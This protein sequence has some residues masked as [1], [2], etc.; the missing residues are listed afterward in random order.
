MPVSPALKF[1]VVGEL[2]LVRCVIALPLEGAP[3][4]RDEA[5]TS[6]EVIVWVVNVVPV[7]NRRLAPVVPAVVSILLDI[8]IAEK[9]FSVSCK[10]QNTDLQMASH[11][12]GNWTEHDLHSVYKEHQRPR[13]RCSLSEKLPTRWKYKGYYKLL[14]SVYHFSKFENDLKAIYLKL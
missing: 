7:A 14:Q 3:V 10:M 12:S 11:K 1:V 8:V 9:P 6:S 4:P 13:K 5:N 2:G